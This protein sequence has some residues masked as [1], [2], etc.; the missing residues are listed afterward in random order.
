MKYILFL[1]SFYQN[2]SIIKKYLELVIELQSYT[3]F[4][5]RLKLYFPFFFA[6]IKQLFQ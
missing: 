1:E 3:C 5:Q 4:S 6:K 2:D